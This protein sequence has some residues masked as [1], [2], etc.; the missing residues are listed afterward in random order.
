MKRGKGILE[1][2]TI[3]K[4]KMPLDRDIRHVLTKLE[5][6]YNETLKAKK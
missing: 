4:I 2:N 5:Q 3:K 6:K 1:T